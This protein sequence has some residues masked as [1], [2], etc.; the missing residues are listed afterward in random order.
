MSFNIVERNKALQFE[1]PVRLFWLCLDPNDPHPIWG[2]YCIAVAYCIVCYRFDRSWMRTENSAESVLEDERE[3]LFRLKDRWECAH[4]ETA[5]TVMALITLE[6]P[7]GLR[8]K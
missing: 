5:E 8:T 3:A 4:T 7:T 2:H 6:N 1:G